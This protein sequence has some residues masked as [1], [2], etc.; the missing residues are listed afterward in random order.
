MLKVV[1][2]GNESNDASGSLLDEIVRVGARQMLAAALQAEVACYVGAYA[3]ELDEAGRRLVVR[4]GHHQAR[5]VTTAAGAVPVRAPRVNDKRTDPSTGERRRFSS[6]I[7]PAWSRK[8]PRVAEVLPLL[9]LHGL[10]T[11]DFA[12]ALEQF[13]GSDAGLSA[14]TITRLTSQWQDEATAFNKRSLAC[15]DYVYVWVDGIHLK[16]RLEQ[17]KVCLLVMIG[18][19][20]DGTK[21][22]VALADGHRESTESWADLLRSCKRRGM[23]APVLAV[24]DGALGFWAAVRDVF[25]DTAEQRCWFHKIANVLNCLPKSAQPG[26]KAAMAEI[27]NAEDKEHA[28]AAVKTF[29]AHYGAKWPKAVTK[30]SEDLDVLL[31]FYDYPAEHWIHLRTT[32][33]IESTF[34]TVRLR[35]RVTKGPG[36]RAAGVAMAFKLIESAQSRWRAVNAPHLVALVRA[37]ARFERGV[38]VERPDELAGDQQVA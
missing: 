7:L 24:G 11:S 9:Y 30:I 14:A 37:G 26:A 12:P 33:P 4:N 5:E 15:T 16:V 6:A 20:A 10:S 36:S 35:Q 23:A 34:A 21:E 8:S 28:E 2:E 1:H 19:R 25:P 31:A 3:G 29:A 32:N 18:V 17:D 38:L 27:W 22:L 13:L